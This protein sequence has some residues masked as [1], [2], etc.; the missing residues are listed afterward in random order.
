[1]FFAM[2]RRPKDP[3][4]HMAAGPKTKIRLGLEILEDRTL[5]STVTWINA[6]SGDWDTA[7]NWRDDM[8][9]NRLPGPADDA[10]IPSGGYAVTHGS[11]VTDAVASI[12]NQAAIVLS[13]GTL[14]VSGNV[15]GTG[16]FT[17]SGGTL[18]N[19][20]VAAGTT[21]TGTTLGGTLSDIT[22]NGILDLTGGNAY[23]L[24]ADV[25]NGLTLNGVAKLGNNQATTSGALRL[26]NTEI[27]GG[28]GDIVLGT[29]STLGNNG[30]RVAVTQLGI[31]VILGP[32]L[33]I[34]G[35]SGMVEGFVNQ[36]TISVDVAN[37]TIIALALTNDNGTL[38]VGSAPGANLEIVAPLV[39]TN[40]TLTLSGPGHVSL[41][42]TI[43][44]GTVTCVNGGQLQGNFDG[45]TESILSGVTLRDA[46]MVTDSTHAVGIADGLTL[47]GPVNLNGSL[48]CTTTE[49][50][51][52]SGSLVFSSSTHNLLVS[53]P[54]TITVTLGPQATIRGL[55]VT[56]YHTNATFINEGTIGPDPGGQFFIKMNMTNRN[57]TFSAAIGAYLDVDNNS[58]IDNNDSTLTLSGPGGLFLSRNSQL[59]AGTIHGGTLT[60]VNGAKLSTGYIGFL[61]AVTILDLE[62]DGYFDVTNLTVS[63]TLMI[64]S[65]DGSASAQLNFYGALQDSGDILFGGSTQNRIL[66]SSNQTLTLNPGSTIHGKNGSIDMPITNEGTIT[67][68]VANGEI[69]L[70][71]TWT[72]S[73]IM[74]AENGGTLACGTLA[75]SGVNQG[76]ITADTGGGTIGIGG[77][78]TNSGIVMAEN[79]GTLNCGTPTNVSGGTLTGGVWKVF[80]NS[81]LQINLMPAFRTCA[82]TIVLDGSDSHFYADFSQDDLAYL[83]TIAASG[84]LTIENGRSW[85]RRANF[86]NHGSLTIGSASTLT[87]PGNYIDDGSLAV[88]A[89]GTLNLSGAG[90]IS[91]S[92]QLDG[93]L[94]VSVAATLEMAV[95]AA[96][97]G[98]LNV[99][100]SLVVDAGATLTLGGTYS[101][102]GNLTVQDGG[103]LDLTGTFTNFANHTLTGGSYDILGTFQFT[104]ANIMANGAQITL[105]GPDAQIVDENGNDAIA[106]FAMNQDGASFT[107]QNGSAEF[108]AGD[109]A[110]VGTLVVGQGSTFAPAGTY[111]QTAGFTILNGGTLGAGV[112]VDLEGGIL[113]GSGTIAASLQN[114]AEIDIGTIEA[115][116]SLTIAGD[117]TQTSTGMLTLK[118]GGY[119]PGT[120][121]DQLNVSGTATLDG[122]VNITLLNGFVPTPGDDFQVLTFGTVTGDFT[123]YNG[124][125][126]GGGLSLAP[127]YDSNSLTLVTMSGPA[128]ST[129][130]QGLRELAI[131]DGGLAEALGRRMD[132]QS[133]PGNDTTI[134]RSDFFLAFLARSCHPIPQR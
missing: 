41:W 81:T 13:H 48:W 10:V 21:I 59:G 68:D 93:T 96:G 130:I 56:F 27:V 103:L 3:A 128:S 74:R 105:D 46:T 98:N 2:F 85:T 25:I 42:G 108:P 40:S 79:G 99:T 84:S 111:L 49:T 65:A 47:I 129:Q 35:A 44:G 61:D 18:G 123:N 101:Q 64:G 53:S 19:A 16:L 30:N 38:A 17:L 89:G 97:T 106:N 50:I 63:G 80:D 115:A 87:V 126:L 62:L 78:W 71:G 57:G 24:Y 113:S 34:H 102:F 58:V 124:L 69:M 114:A 8:G 37:G 92:A 70:N 23:G 83:N 45:N 32:D 55:Y 131:L 121:F 110:N 134:R 28:S 104:G 31:T 14:N 91:G 118:I 82:A 107:L 6:S 127:V 117:Y 125:D 12:T 75:H 77:N 7:A 95:S 52:G 86:T 133:N 54:D 132:F 1:M 109:V 51:G 94:N 15:S 26:S 36:G 116:G 73:G 9:N 33:K 4:R 5:L 67:A 90:T 88:L 39:N 60:S 72:N 11:S 122:T 76:T 100:G 22:I 112:L 20:T 120:D 66:I 43:E 29:Y 119:N